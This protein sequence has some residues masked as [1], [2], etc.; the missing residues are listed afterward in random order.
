[1]TTQSAARKALLLFLLVIAPQSLSAV[2]TVSLAGYWQFQLD[3]TDV[4]ER[5]QWF[6]QTFRSP[7]G[8]RLPGIL[9]SQN[10]G[11]EIST[12]TPWVLSLYDRFWYLR[13]EYKPYTEPKNIKVPFLSQPP[14]HYLGVAWYQR[15]IQVPSHFVGRRVLLTL[16]RPHWE[17]TVWVDGQKIGSAKSLV[18]PHIYDLGPVTPGRHRL[19]I[20]VDNRLI[21]PYRP[22]AH[23]V[24]DSLGGSWNG[25]VGRIEL[26]DT[27]R[28]WIDE[29]RVF[30]NLAQKTMLIK[31]K[32]GNVTGRSG[33]GT[34]TAIWPDLGVVPAN[35][36]EQG[37][38]VEVEVPIRVD[39]ETWDE[40]HPKVL[41]LRLWLKG[42]GVDEYADLKIGLRDFHADGKQFIL[43]G[44]PIIF[45]GTHSGGDFPLT[46]YPPTDVESWQQIEFSRTHT[47]RYLKLISL[48]GFGPDKTTSLSELA[49]M[50]AGPKFTGK[51]G[52]IE[53]QRSRSA[54]PEIEEVPGVD[55]PA[56]PKA[57]PVRPKP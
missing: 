30:P 1:M 49:M 54:K 42:A 27:G 50:Y 16:E 5:Q 32:I 21:M 4:G 55:K 33:A 40:F 38:T 43:N 53:Y 18:A 7:W 17:T 47:A 52:T 37:G 9:Q 8:I 56:K 14:R 39:A 29:V 31:T 23:S 28:V 57:S 41:P 45:R 44:K 26:S 22:D 25:I 12:K 24:S 6:M 11:E 51:N 2:P 10:F 15:E 46:G 36:D 34:L 19:S 20:R 35:W 13:E 48:T 3:P